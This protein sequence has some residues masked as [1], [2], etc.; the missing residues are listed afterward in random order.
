MELPATLT[1][2]NPRSRSTS[3]I[4]MWAY[5]R[6][7]PPPSATA[8]RGRRAMPRSASGLTPADPAAT[9]RDGRHPVGMTA[10][11]R[12]AGRGPPTLDVVTTTIAPLKLG[13]LAVDPAVV[14]AP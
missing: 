1:T 4:P 3:R 7:P 13:T 6:A 5:P 8:T 12:A 2:S 10:R 9:G 11:A 14:L